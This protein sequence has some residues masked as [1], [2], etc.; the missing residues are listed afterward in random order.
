M[1]DSA[2]MPFSAGMG[3][4]GMS[5]F[6]E[7]DDT[8][9]PP[10]C[11]TDHLNG[12]Q[13]AAIIVRVLV[14]EGVDMPLS[15]LP[16][17]M[18]TDLTRTMGEM[19]LVD[20]NT[21]NAVVS[22]YIDMLEQVGLSFPDG[23]DGALSLLDGRLDAVATQQLR[24]LAR[25]EFGRDSWGDLETA[26][27]EELMSLLEAEST[28]VGAVLLSK[29]SIDKAAGL[30]AR[31]PADLAQ[32][33]AMSVAETDD[34]DPDT[35]ARIGAALAQ[36]VSDK[37]VRAFAKPSTR[38]VGEILNSTS[39]DLRDRLLAGLESV[40]RGFATG[41]RKSIF[42]FQDIPAR[43]DTRDVPTLMREIPPDDMMFIIAANAEEDQ[44][45]IE[46]LLTNMSRRIAD[47]LREDAAAL[48]PPGA[49]QKNETMV[50]IMASLRMMVD[51]GTLPLKPI[52][53]E[54]ES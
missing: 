13:K 24:M 19:R 1:T 43:I 26:P 18:Q 35:V 14:A 50:R 45:T 12:L 29:L 51:A 47:T 36:Q 28:V 54:E 52:D 44:A 25:G 16:A 49:K 11:S 5:P 53:E 27:D 7:S 37:P 4:M 41:V 21:M 33:L 8:P 22:E 31:M 15:G 30:L 48:P 20:R 40:D 6:D 3:G 2:M 46:F 23:L 9:A 38:R 39:S 10:P 34:I 17:Q 42:T 32:A